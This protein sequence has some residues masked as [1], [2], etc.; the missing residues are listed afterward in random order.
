APQDPAAA[1]AAAMR[2]W[3]QQY[4]AQWQAYQQQQ[5]MLGQGGAPGAPQQ[6]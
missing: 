4:G 6:P 2:Q 1:A 5:A 3:E